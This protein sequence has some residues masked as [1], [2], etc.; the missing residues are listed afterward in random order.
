MRKVFFAVLLIFFSAISVCT[1]QAY[2]S[3]KRVLLI[4]SYNPAFPTFFQQINGLNSVFKPAGILLDIEF[5][6]SKRFYKPENI[7]AFHNLLKLKLTGLD[8]YDIIVT[9][10]DN[11][12]EFALEYHDE[13]FHNI[14]VVFFGVNQQDLARSM[15]SNDL[16]TGV[17]E[18]VSMHETLEL[19]FDL[20][21]K[22]KNI[23]AIVDASP[24]G[25][26]DLETFKGHSAHFIGKKLDVLSLEKYSWDEFGRKL[27]KLSDKDAVL[28]LS[29]Y[30]DKSGT[31]KLFGDSLDL[32]VS[33]SKVPVFHLW[34]HGLGQGILGGKVISQFEQGVAA[35]NICLDIFNGQQVKNIPVV[36]GAEV[37]KFIF[38][39][40]ILKKFHINKDSLPPT[41]LIVNQSE[42][43]FYQYRK[44]ISLSVSFLVLLL[45][46]TGA[47]VVYVFRLRKAEEKARKSEERFALAMDAS[48][49]G[50]WDWE[51]GSDNVYYSPS[52][53]VM[54]GYKVDEVPSHVDVWVDLIHLADKEAVINANKDCI[55]NRVDSFE[56][57]YRMQTKSGKWIW[58][59]GRGKA[60]ERDKT[61]R[62]I[63]VVGTHTDITEHKNIEKELRRLRNYLTNIIDSMP[64]ILIGLDYKG[65]VTQ[66]NSEAQRVTGF[67]AAEAE[68]KFLPDVFPRLAPQLKWVEKSLSS[69]QIHT[70]SRVH[71]QENEEDKF[72]D[73]TIYPLSSNGVEGVVI[74][75]DDVTKRV[76]LEEMIVQSEKMVSIGSLAAG[77]AH[78]INNPLGAIVQGTQNLSRRLSLDL[79]IN[80]KIA[81]QYNLDL[82]S[83]HKYL[84][85]RNIF[86]IIEGINSSGLRAATIVTNMLSFCRKSDNS[87]KKNN[88]VSLLENALEMAKSEYDL[89]RKY[90][91]KKLEIEREYAL[92]IPD[93]C[94][95]GNEIQQVFLNLIKNGAYAVSD[96]IYLDTS[97]KLFL[98]LRSE[99]NM[100]VAEIEDNGLGMDETARKRAFEPFFTTK[101]TG[102]GTGL[103]LSVSYFIITEQHNGHME[104]FSSP[105]NW[106]RF[107]VKL[108]ANMDC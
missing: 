45:F 42:S 37:N 90:D 59:L 64:S 102:D 79:P 93:I 46:F 57:E 101:P 72:E 19:A 13:F 11:A 56:V 28:L 15:N 91:F 71:T 65:E 41:S 61:G 38:D 55:E 88:L 26:G 7:L 94:C 20:F 104:V 1:G 43:F 23:Y 85:H 44:A 5:M 60:V 49:D 10:D 99:R 63:R 4:S 106:T 52:Y 77:M 87:V 2:A 100:V 83:V 53:K 96:K 36:E 21:P 107:V 40:N 97:P 12:F 14:P 82:D 8:P 89:N 18:A 86:N 47:L 66:W 33:H 24:S 70:D 31:G 35:A 58:I 22:V 69:H 98:R 3:A 105:G 32:I 68:G 92:D 84:S 81:E 78:E 95:D 80:Y 74:R 51:I 73:I 50:L 17:I 9:S 30:R 39:Y 27:E 48:R 108:P 54:L 67:S 29:A 34:E 16:V 62:A 76:R 75:V 6:D 25:Q 103:G